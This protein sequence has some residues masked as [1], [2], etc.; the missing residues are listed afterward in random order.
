[1]TSSAGRLTVLVLGLLLIGELIYLQDPSV[2]QRFERSNSIAV[3]VSR[4]SLYSRMSFNDCRPTSRP[5][6]SFPAT[7]PRIYDR[8]TFTTWHGF[9]RVTVEYRA[10]GGRIYVSSSFTGHTT[11]LVCGYLPVYGQVAAAQPGWWR[12]I[13]RV[14]DQVLRSR[15]FKIHRVQPDPRSLV[16]PLICRRG[17]TASLQKPHAGRLRRSFARRAALVAF[18]RRYPDLRIVAIV[19]HGT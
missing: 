10:P 17:C 15:S 14:G 1:V 5:A 9:H 3:D 16:S 8:E 19:D 4:L 18:L 13:L 11:T 7:S 2:L 12:I 6:I